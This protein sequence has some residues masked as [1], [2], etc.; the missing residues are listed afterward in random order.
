[1]PSR[2][3][4]CEGTILAVLVLAI[5]ARAADKEKVLRNFTGGRD[6]ANSPAGLIVDTAG[7]LY[8]TTFSGGVSGCYSGCGV[9]FELMPSANG[10]WK[11]TVLHAFAGGKDGGGS[12]AGLIM[13]AAGNLY[14]TTRGGTV[15]E[16][17]PT[18]TGRWKETVLYSFCSLTNCADGA[19]PWSNLIFDPA[20]NLYG[21]TYNG[22]GG[23]CV[24]GCGVVYELTLGP[25]GWKE[26]VLHTFTGGPDGANPVSG[27]AIDAA[28][29]LYGT[30]LFGGN[31]NNCSGS[32]Y[33]PGCGVA[34]KLTPTSN[35]WK[36]KVIHTFTN[37]WDGANPAA[38]LTLDSAG[39]LYG[40][41]DSGDIVGKCPGINAGCG[42]VF[43]LTPASSDRWK[44]T[45]LHAFTGG[46][47]GGSPQAP[48]IFD[49]VGNLYGT[50][51]EGP[52]T[53]GLVFELTP[54]SN[55]WKEKVLHTFDGLDGANPGAGLAIDSAGNLFGTTYDGG[56][57]GYGVV[58]EVT[59]TR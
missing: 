53:N 31:R 22:G 41:T 13:D 33:T 46:K 35:G 18:K 38:G 45:V 25:H 52:A 54:T 10:G 17:T 44:E 40:T 20:G 48:V 5:A 3:L 55:G 16:L 59:T 11:E 34:F 12:F 39:N 8:G 26:T 24:S 28:G 23:T 27:L 57:H 49:A 29:T 4:W 2:R 30:A 37:G 21:T 36:W 50:T 9:V 7:N 47:D 1:M 42:V 56:K 6:G 43:E 51:W 19:D 58:F 32:G 15:F 14:G